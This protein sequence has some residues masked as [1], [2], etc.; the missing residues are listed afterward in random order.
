MRRCDNS[1]QGC[2]YGNASLHIYMCG[3]SKLFRSVQHLWPLLSGMFAKRHVEY[4][5][6]AWGISNNIGSIGFQPLQPHMLLS[7]GQLN[8]IFFH[9]DR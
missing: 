7:A 8:L 6:G 3:I 2:G 5:V 4:N 9:A 1:L